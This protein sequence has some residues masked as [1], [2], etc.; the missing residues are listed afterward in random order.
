[1]DTGWLV[2]PSKAV[3]DTA[4]QN[5]MQDPRMNDGGNPVPFDGKRMIDGGFEMIFET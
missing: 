2:W 1:M 4:W 3:R 5:V